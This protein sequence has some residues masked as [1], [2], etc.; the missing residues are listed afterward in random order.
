[1]GHRIRHQDLVVQLTDD[2][3]KAVAKEACIMDHSVVVDVVDAINNVRLADPI[4]TIRRSPDGRVLAVR[5][6]NLDEP[7][8]TFAINAR[9]GAS[10]LSDPNESVL[11]WPII[12][13]PKA[14]ER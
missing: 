1:M 5:Q 11:K 2:E 13:K 6:P 8:E 14:D 12:Y 7:Y 4:G 10:W 3:V 9:G